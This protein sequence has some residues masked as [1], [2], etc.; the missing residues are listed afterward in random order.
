MSV[1]DLSDK[2]EIKQIKQQSFNP[3]EKQQQ[4]QG[5]FKIITYK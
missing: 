3:K 1:S 5:F 4:K 2:E